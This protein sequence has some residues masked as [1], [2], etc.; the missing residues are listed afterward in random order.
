MDNNGLIDVE[1]FLD[2][3][4]AHRVVLHI[5]NEEL[6]LS[7]HQREEM[8]ANAERERQNY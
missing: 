7:Q 2:R 6:E 4:D 1:A 8:I 3:D 5:T